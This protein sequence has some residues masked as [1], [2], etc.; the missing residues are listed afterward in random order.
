MSKRL[1]GILIA[2]TRAN[3]SGFSLVAILILLVSLAIAVSVALE[4]ITPA[5]QES[6]RVE[7]EATMHEIGHAIVGDYALGGSMV[8]AD[9]GYVGDVGAMPASLSSLLVNPGGYSTWSGPYLRDE[10]T[11]ATNKSIT[12]SWGTA[13]SYTGGTEISSS[14][15]GSAIT[16]SLAKSTADLLTCGFSGTVEGANGV[17]PGSSSGNLVAIVTYPD[18]IGGIKQDT[19]TVS[20]AGSFS[21]ASVLPIGIHAIL[22]KDLVASDSVTSFVRL[23]PRSSITNTNTGVLRLPNTN[24]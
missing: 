5:L 24:Y 17:A 10:F 11:E 16:Y 19:A 3:E 1:F 13:I 8:G 18:G 23:L 20:S 22:V 4:S 6:R 15:S 12:D 9:F 2:E 14:G 7:T 21:F